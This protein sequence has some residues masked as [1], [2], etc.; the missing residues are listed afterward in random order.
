M[1]AVLMLFWAWPLWLPAIVTALLKA[2]LGSPISFLL[3]SIALCV[4]I[5]V[6]LAF[7]LLQ[8]VALPLIGFSGLLA[9]TLLGLTGCL[10][11]YRYDRRRS[12]QV[13]A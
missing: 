10:L 2:R 11:V 6:S 13:R 3:K 12:S 7:G 9:H 8:V 5:E 1:F 4:V